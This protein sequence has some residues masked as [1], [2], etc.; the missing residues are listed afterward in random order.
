M[1]CYHVVQFPVGVVPSVCVV[2][3]VVAD[4]VVVIVTDVYIVLTLLCTL[5]IFPH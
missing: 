1:C 3:A 2:N 5:I 4:A